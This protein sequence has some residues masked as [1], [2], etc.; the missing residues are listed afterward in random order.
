[1]TTLFLGTLE[2]RVF[3][4]NMRAVSAITSMTRGTFYNHTPSPLDA[5]VGRSE[6]KSTTLTKSEKKNYNAS[7]FRLLG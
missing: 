4:D 6:E 1:M 2:L 7:T 5:I 3:I